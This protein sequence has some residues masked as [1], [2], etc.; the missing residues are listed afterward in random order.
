[1]CAA[2]TLEKIRSGL[3]G[4]SCDGEFR[5][6]AIEADPANHYIFHAGTFFLRDCSP[7]LGEARAHLEFDA[8]LFRK[9]YSPRL[10]YLRAAT[11]H[12][13]QFFVSDFVQFF[14]LFHNSRVAGENS[15]DVGEN[16]TR[17]CVQRASQRNRC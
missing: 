7:G 16:L 6:V 17:I 2:A 11:G 4:H 3:V 13:E 15:I 1:M 9:F 14:C 8:E 5:L 10:H 12:F